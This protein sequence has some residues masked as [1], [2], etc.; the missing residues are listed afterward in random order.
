ML[1]DLARF[2]AAL[3]I[4]AFCFAVLAD[5]AWNTRCGALGRRVPADSTAG[6]GRCV[7][8]RL[9]VADRTCVALKFN[10]FGARCVGTPR[11][12]TP[13]FSVVLHIA[14]ISNYDT[15]L[16]INSA[17]PALHAHNTFRSVCSQSNPVD[18]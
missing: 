3:A 17:H 1:A 9:I 10:R 12:H 2:A 6:A 5:R 8:S 7:N 15:A 16:H 13:V 4:G 11:F 14:N 18:V